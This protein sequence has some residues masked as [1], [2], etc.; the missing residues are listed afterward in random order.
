MATS[1]KVVNEDSKRVKQLEQ[2][3]KDLKEMMMKSFTNSANNAISSDKDRD[4]VFI[5]LVLGILNLAT[6]GNGRGSVYTF[7]EFGEEQSIPYSDAKSLIKNNKKFIKEGKVY[8]AD[9]AL[10]LSERL[11][12]DYEHIL[13]R[14]SLIELFDKDKTTFSKL[15]T[16]IPKSQKETFARIISSRI[17]KGEDV[18]MNIVGIVDKALG[19]DIM[20]DIN[21]GKG[22][23]TDNK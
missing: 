6:E 7:R 4:V 2:E 23:D 15:F 10:I 12:K 16:S 1:K 5:S 3:L 21:N 18:D 17:L 19:I 8:I 22:T 14:D 9:E 11:D 13:D 20:K